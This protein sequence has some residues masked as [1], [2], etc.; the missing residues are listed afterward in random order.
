MNEAQKKLQDEIMQSG[1]AISLDSKQST[2]TRELL[3]KARRNELKD[4]N[5]ATLVP[6]RPERDVMPMVDQSSVMGAGML[7]CF[8]S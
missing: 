8:K 1:K 3:M 7:D 4:N 2:S 5:N 6:E